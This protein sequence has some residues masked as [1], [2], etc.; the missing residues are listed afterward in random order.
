MTTNVGICVSTNVGLDMMATAGI[1][2]HGAMTTNVGDRKS[3]KTM[4]FKKNGTF[5]K[6]AGDRKSEKNNDIQKK[7]ENSDPTSKIMKNPHAKSYKT[8][9]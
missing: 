9:H 3:E 1:R 2:P 4:I 5:E 7:L 6:F 8:Q